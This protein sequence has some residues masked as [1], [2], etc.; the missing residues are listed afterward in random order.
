M[1]AIGREWAGK[2]LHRPG[3]VGSRG[4]GLVLA[5]LSVRAQDNARR[6]MAQLLDR[7]FAI[8]DGYGNAL[9]SGINR[10]IDNQEVAD[11]DTEVGHGSHCGDKNVA[12]RCSMR[13]SS[14]L[15]R[16]LV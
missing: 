2:E 8:D 9:V 3:V 1:I 10:A 14:R 11:M 12:S 15:R 13:C 7:K 16:S 4:S 6:R 5:V